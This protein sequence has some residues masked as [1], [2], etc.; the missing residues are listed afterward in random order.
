MIRSAALLCFLLLAACAGGRGDVRVID[1]STAVYEVPT[2]ANGTAV[3]PQAKVCR[4]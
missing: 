4:H 1:A 3:T 2:K